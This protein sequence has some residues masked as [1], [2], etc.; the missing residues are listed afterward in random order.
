M[1]VHNFE[2]LFWKKVHIIIEVHQS[3]MIAQHTVHENLH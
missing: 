3:F 2:Y 1:C